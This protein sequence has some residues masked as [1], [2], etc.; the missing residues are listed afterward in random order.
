M[1]GANGVNEAP[2]ETA[3][4]LKNINKKINEYIVM[5]HLPSSNNK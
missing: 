5:L 3:T 1:D 4:K 2:D